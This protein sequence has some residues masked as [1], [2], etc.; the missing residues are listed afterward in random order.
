M[1]AALN[2]QTQFCYGEIALGP[3]VWRWVFILSE[4]PIQN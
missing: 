3:R 1:S 4:D 2:L